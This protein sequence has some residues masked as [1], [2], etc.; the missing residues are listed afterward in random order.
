MLSLMVRRF[1]CEDHIYF[2][3]FNMFLVRKADKEYFT[4]QTGF[5][6]NACNSILNS[7]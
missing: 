3:L 6:T 1:A 4:W 7:Y 5:L 2:S